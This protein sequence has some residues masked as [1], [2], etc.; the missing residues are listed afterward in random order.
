M[1]MPVF[2][3]VLGMHRTG[4]NLLISAL[5]AHKEVTICGELFQEDESSRKFCGNAAG[6]QYYR[7]G[8]DGAT[9][10]K[11]HVFH[12]RYD[13][14]TVAV[15]FK[16]FFTHAIT[17]PAS[18]VWSQLVQDESVRIIRIQRQNLLELYLSN[19]V[20]IRTGEWWI[21]PKQNPTVVPAFPL[22]SVALRRFFD[23]ATEREAW[24]DQ[25]F[26]NHAS[27][28]VQY[29][30]DL[31]HSYDACISRVQSFLQLDRQAIPPKI[32]KQAVRSS[33]D[34]IS[35]YRE[36]K[37]SFQSSPYMEFFQ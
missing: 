12:D 1:P 4:S 6:G 16:L 33:S 35:N 32:R 31:L 20:A 11:Q 2:F 36:L 14:R 8:T 26:R 34:Q 29:E 15:G 19:E 3:V 24:A 30:R 17:G 5:D 7:D 23:W 27:M 28:T 9:F 25:V 10:L 37:N 13:Q 21:S 18:S 22:D